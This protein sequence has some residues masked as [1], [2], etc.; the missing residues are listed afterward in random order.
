MGIICVS[1]CSGKRQFYLQETD[2][3]ISTSGFYEHKLYWAFIFLNQHC[4]WICPAVFPVHWGGILGCTRIK[5]TWNNK[6][7]HC[8]LQLC[9]CFK[10][11]A[12]VLTWYCTLTSAR[13]ITFTDSVFQKCSNTVYA[14]AYQNEKYCFP[15]SLFLLEV[16]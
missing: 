7:S 3:W 16:I 13:W 15:E 8:S 4:G 11:K 9:M 1:R 2:V 5:T 6:I 14:V 12:F 10:R